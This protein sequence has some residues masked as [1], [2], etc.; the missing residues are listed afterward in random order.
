MFAKFGV[1]SADCV[2][3]SIGTITL[4]T[5]LKS[6]EKKI[7]QFKTWKS[8]RQFLFSNAMQQVRKDIL[9]Q[10]KLH[11][12]TSRSYLQLML[13]VPLIGANVCMWVEFL[14]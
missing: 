10:W 13:I 5:S 2:N 14:A 11:F 7:S 1:S 8:L 6:L 4:G 12:L 9:Q 3:H